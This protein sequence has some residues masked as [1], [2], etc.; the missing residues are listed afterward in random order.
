[1]RSKGRR[2]PSARSG[3]SGISRRDFARSATVAA[4]TIVAAPGSVLG[5]AVSTATATASAAIQQPAGET[6]KLSAQALAEVESKVAEIMRRYGD[7]LDD[8]QKADIRRLVREAQPMLEALRAFPLENSD[9]P[10]T[11]LHLVT[12]AA[13]SRRATAA[14]KP[15][16]KPGG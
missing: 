5:A 12:S 13:P 10:A 6:P 8:A 9:E 16:A 4:A 2:K 15:P 1:M 7:R 3:A 14:P 11:V